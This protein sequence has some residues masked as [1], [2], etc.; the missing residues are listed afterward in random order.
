[1]TSK[2]AD[3]VGSHKLW[4]VSTLSNAFTGA[5]HFPPPQK[6]RVGVAGQ[7]RNHL[8]LGKHVGAQVPGHVWD[9]PLT[10]QHKPTGQTVITHYK[11]SGTRKGHFHPFTT[12]VMYTSFCLRG[13]SFIWGKPK[14]KLVPSETPR[15]KRT[16]PGSFSQKH[17]DFFFRLF[18]STTPISGISVAQ[19]QSIEF[20]NGITPLSPKVNKMVTLREYLDFDKSQADTFH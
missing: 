3:L 7:E 8:R 13:S 5:C 12:N 9:R 6:H 10:L 15:T 20:H 19:A 4:T 2:D 11:L 14:K 1:M 16:T 18:S 17:K